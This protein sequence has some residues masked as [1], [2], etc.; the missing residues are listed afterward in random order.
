MYD[1]YLVIAG[2]DT[3]GQP[4]LVGRNARDKGRMYLIRREQ[5]LVYRP[6]KVQALARYRG[7]D[8]PSERAVEQTFYN[9][10]P[11]K[12]KLVQAPGWLAPD[13]KF[14]PCHYL[15]HGRIACALARIYHGVQLGDGSAYLE[16]HNWL[17][18]TAHGEWAFMPQ[19]DAINNVQIDAIYDLI[20]LEP[21]STYAL[22]MRNLLRL[23]L[24]YQSL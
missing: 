7:K 21:Q 1:T 16:D 22:N 15:E 5:E 4:T 11:P 20:E 3:I 18:V 13:G 10:F 6:R 2:D 19:M 24:E 17:H 23:V 8:F 9:E 14:F 12:H